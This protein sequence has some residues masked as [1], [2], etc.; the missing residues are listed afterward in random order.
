AA[1]E[2]TLID[3][4]MSRKKRKQVVDQLAATWILQGYIDANRRI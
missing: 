3:A 2:R 1:A 4:D